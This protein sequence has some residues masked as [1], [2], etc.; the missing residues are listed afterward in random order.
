MDPLARETLWII[1]KHGENESFHLK[2]TRVSKPYGSGLLERCRLLKPQFWGRDV[3]NDFERTLISIRAYDVFLDFLLYSGEA[4]YCFG[5]SR[6]FV[7]AGVQS[8]LG[9]RVMPANSDACS[10]YHWVYFK[11]YIRAI[12]TQELCWLKIHTSS[13]FCLNCE[14][15]NPVGLFDGLPRGHTRG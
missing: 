4:W 9:E 8:H 5:A 11:V 13:S 3:V 12:K 15:V 10:S 14:E 6:P 2:L 1:W 7:P